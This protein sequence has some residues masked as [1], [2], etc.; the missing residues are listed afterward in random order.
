[1]KPKEVTFRHQNLPTVC[2]S[3]DIKVLGGRREVRCGV[4]LS[5]KLNP[6]HFGLLTDYLGFAYPDFRLA[7]ESDYS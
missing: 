7:W 2:T 5:I 3:P 1:M 4:L 6:E